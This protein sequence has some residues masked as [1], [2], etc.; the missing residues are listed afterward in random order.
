MN[1]WNPW[2]LVPIGVSILLLCALLGWIFRLARKRPP[3][4]KSDWKNMGKIFL[5]IIC[6]AAMAA[7]GC[8]GFLLQIRQSNHREGIFI[9]LGLSGLAV[10]AA[11]LLWWAGL[12]IWHLISV[13]RRPSTGEVKNNG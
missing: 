4:V 8:Y 7:G 12:G 5:I 10:F 3:G 11:G 9:G 2:S 1:H 13:L 6:G